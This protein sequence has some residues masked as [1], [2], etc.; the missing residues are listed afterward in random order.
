MGTKYKLIITTPTILSLRNVDEFQIG[1]EGFLAIVYAHAE[2]DGNEAWG[3]PLTT[4][5][6]VAAEVWR[7]GMDDD[8]DGEPVTDA[9]GIA[10]LLGCSPEGL[11]A[12]LDEMVSDRRLAAY[13]ARYDY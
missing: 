2:T 10:A 8:G 3:M 11:A 13:E 7:D 6:T 5:V 9:A 1:G 12:H 4:A